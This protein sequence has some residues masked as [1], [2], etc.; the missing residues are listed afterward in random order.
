MHLYLKILRQNC[1]EW[2]EDIFL[3]KAPC[4][5]GRHHPKIAS[6]FCAAIRQSLELNP[7]GNMVF[8]SAIR[9]ES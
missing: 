6:D 2:G 1:R 3:I 4:F 8:Y 5:F 9:F 7:I